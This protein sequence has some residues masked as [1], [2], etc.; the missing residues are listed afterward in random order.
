MIVIRFIGGLGNQFFQ[1]ALGRHLSLIHNRPLRFD[2]SGYT[3]TKPDAKQGTRLFGLDAF[4]VCGHVATPQE[5]QLFQIRRRPGVGGHLARL[6][7]RCAPLRFRRYIVERKTDFWHFCPSVLTSAM[8]ETVLIEGYWQSEKYFEGIADTIRN[9]LRLKQPAEGLNAEM[10]STI[11]AVD[12]VSV[13]VRHGDNA[14]GIAKDHGVL[15]IAYYEQATRRI[16]EQVPKPHFFVFSDDPDWAKENLTLPDPTV[17]VV[18]NGDEKNYEDLRLMASCKH[19]VVANSSFSWWGAW[20]GRKDGQIVFA[21]EKYMQSDRSH[22]DY[23]DY[24][25]SWWNRLPMSWR[26]VKSV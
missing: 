1:Y 4:S 24:Y 15:P 12:S 14:T 22:W 19:H 5:L 26:S 8:A 9:D 13:H 6:S 10:L 17:F 11:A 7:N 3:A 21:P 23:R 2:I 20:L 25:P 16:K 18:H